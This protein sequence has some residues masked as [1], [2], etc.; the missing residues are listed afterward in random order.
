MS[1]SEL[2]RRTRLALPTVSRITDRLLQEGLIAGEEKVMMTAMG[3]PSLPLSIA[4]Q[5]A[6]AFGVAV[7]ADT[8]TVSLAHLSGSVVASTSE[9]HAGMTREETVE[10]IAL[11]IAG[12][13][14]R[15]RVAPDRVCGLGLGLPG[16]FVSD[17][18]RI[19]APLGMED[20]A[21]GDLERDLGGALGLPLLVEND[22]TA[23]A[24]GEYQ[25]GRGDRSS[26]L[27]FLYL[28]RGLGG[29]VV[30]DGRLLRGRRGNAGEFTGLLHPDARSDRPTLQVLHA[31]ANEAGETYTS[32]DDMVRGI[33]PRSEIVDRWIERTVPA[34][35]AIISAIGAIL[36]PDGIVIGGRL[37]GAIADRLIARL[38]FYSV[39]VR[40]R[41]RAFPTVYSS[42]VMGDAVSLGASALCFDRLFF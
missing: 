35:N 33:D 3:Q 42:S 40:G 31:I 19:N 14:E 24:L 37:P 2:A 7:R 17:P 16:F 10:R 5:A 8:L 23:A 4:P 39:P 1:R 28:D 26:S 22:G 41:D 6:Y 12:L 18:K 21:T 38:E 34:T 20:W 36:D 27:A 29:G 15:S 13:M 9:P 11:A 30:E 32:L 25:Y